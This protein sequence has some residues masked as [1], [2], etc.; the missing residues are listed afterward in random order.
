MGILSFFSKT[1]PLSAE[2]TRL[3]TGSFTVD[4][5]GRIIISTLPQTFSRGLAKDIGRLILDTFHS[6]Q[7]TQ[8][9]LTELSIQYSAL[10]ITARSLRGGAII[11]F[12]PR[13]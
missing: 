1:Q 8:L 6:A 4:S 13:A 12:T 11:F 5:Q 9:P 10:K 7:E 3:P 2:M